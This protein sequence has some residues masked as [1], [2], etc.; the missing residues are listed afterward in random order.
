MPGP[1]RAILVRL[2]PYILIGNVP[3]LNRA[4]LVRP[5]PYILIGNDKNDGEF[6]NYCHIVL[7][8]DFDSNY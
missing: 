3:G 5:K 6:L 2:K 7:S 8:I 4:I 1:N